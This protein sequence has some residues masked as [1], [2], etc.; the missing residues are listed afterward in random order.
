V[1]PLKDPIPISVTELG[2]VIEVKFEHP[3]KDISPI[4]V[5]ELGIDIDVIPMHL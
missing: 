3:A 4:L 5:T 2:R 1:Q